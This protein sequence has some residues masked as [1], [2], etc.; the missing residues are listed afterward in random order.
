MEERL[1]I[2]VSGVD[3]LIDRLGEWSERGSSANIYDGNVGPHIN[4]SKFAKPAGQ[5]LNEIASVW[6]AG[7][8]VDWDN[9]YPG[10]KPPRIALP[11]YPF[12][13]ER[14]WISDSLAPENRTLSIA[15]LHPL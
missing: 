10:T 15:Q 2:V 11:T 13:R 12:A 1:A 6:V 14:Y 4:R 8:E 7:E 5:S 9:L 3:E